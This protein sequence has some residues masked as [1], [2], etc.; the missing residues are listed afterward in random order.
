LDR[1]YDKLVAYGK[2]GDYPMHMPGHKRNTSL[3]DMVD[4]YTID[5][6]EIEGFDNLHQP[7]EVLLELSERLSRLYGAAYSYPLVNGSTAG[8]LSGI[9]AAV[10]KGDKVLIARNSHKAVYHGVILTET[11]PVYCYPQKTEEMAPYGGILPEDIEKALINNPDIR[12]VVITSPT[13]EGV[14]SDIAAIA[15]I[16]H[17]HG[18]YLLVDEAHG[19]HFGFHEGF[20]VSAVKL[21]ADLVIQSLHK[22]LPALTQSAVLHCNAKE[23]RNRLRKYL[24]IYQSSS[25]SYVLM[26]GIDRCIKLIE[27]NGEE[28]FAKYDQR[29]T[30]F[31]ERL[32]GLKALKLLQQDIIGQYGAYDLDRSKLTISVK[33][34][35]LTGHE[36][37]HLLHRQYKIMLEMEAPDYVLGMTGIADTDEGFDR[38]ATA[39]LE[40]DRHLE[41]TRGHT[42]ALKQPELLKERKDGDTI[43]SPPERKLWPYEAWDRPVREMEFGR[44][45]GQIS[46]SFISLFPPGAPILVPGEVITT[47]LIDYIHSVIRQGVS[48]TGLIGEN[49]DQIEVI[50]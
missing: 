23:L 2:N 50:Q 5:I 17:S 49:R 1:L 48:V 13:Y 33:G 15:G 18:A 21:G 12:L 10:R 6:T 41:D 26:A 27:D 32:K 19:A 24:A 4:P 11:L 39:L 22:T 36:L 25:P 30:G 37:H 38:L 14:V 47:D 28:L 34:T 7:E 31:Y 44:S 20:P 16:A 29:L 35:G 45:N 42:E 3:C 43:L 40:I 9:S 46:A 8:I